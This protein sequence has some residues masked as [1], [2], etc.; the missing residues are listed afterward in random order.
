MLSNGTMSGEKALSMAS[1]L[2]AP[3]H[4]FPLPCRL[5]RILRTVIQAF[6]LPVFDTQQDLALGCAIAG[7]FVGDEHTRHVLA[8]FEELA[9]ELLGCRLV[10][11]ALNQDI[12][13]GAMLINCSP[14]VGRF[15]LD[16]QKHLVKMPL[17][18]RLRTSAT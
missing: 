10:P 5:M 18:S 17:I 7:K 16:G 9:E 11:A 4:A 2:E 1:R 3:H 14:E 6:V 15:A 13:H 8:A 12:Q